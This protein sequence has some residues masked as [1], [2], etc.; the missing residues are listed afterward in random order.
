MHLL[1]LALALLAYAA[2]PD[3]RPTVVVVVGAPGAADYEP[4]FRR[5]ADLWK[6]A[7]AKGGAAF[8][9]IGLDREAAGTDRD[10]LRDALARA[11]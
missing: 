3:D 10:R 9:P 5:W 8:I 7:A 6:Q 1:A 2:P 11:S 4:E